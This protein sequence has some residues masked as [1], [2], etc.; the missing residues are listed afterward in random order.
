[1]NNPDRNLQTALSMELQLD[2]LHRM[3]VQGYISM[4]IPSP[5]TSTQT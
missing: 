5:A 3:D 4:H 2:L 1:M